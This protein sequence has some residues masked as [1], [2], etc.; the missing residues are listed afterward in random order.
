MRMGRLLRLAGLFVLGSGCTLI[1]NGGRN[2]L[3]DPIQYHYNADRFVSGFRNKWLANAAWDE[4]VGANPEYAES[5]DYQCGFKEGFADYLEYGGN[6]QPP[7]LPPRKYWKVHYQTPQGHQAIEEWYAGFAHGAA[8]ARDTGLRQ[9]VTV[10]SHVTSLQPTSY[11]PPARLREEVPLEP[12]P[13]K[14]PPPQ[15]PMPPAPDEEQ[16]RKSKAEKA[17]IQVTTP[18]R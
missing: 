3:H 11:Q 16:A 9:L 6:G 7:P 14:L 4:F 13:E 8:V 12:P 10:P 17:V 2:L 5:P 1:E 18:Y 15:R